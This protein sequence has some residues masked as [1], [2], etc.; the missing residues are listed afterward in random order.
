MGV[1]ARSKKKRRSSQSH[2]ADTERQREKRRPARSKHAE[3]RKFASRRTK[4]LAVDALA[5]WALQTDSSGIAVI[6]N[7]TI[8]GHNELFGSL[9]R[10]PGPWRRFGAKGRRTFR[11]LRELVITEAETLLRT[12]RS[13]AHPTWIQRYERQGDE[14]VEIRFEL[15]PPA[16]SGHGRRITALVL[17]VSDRLRHEH[18]LTETRVHLDAS[19]RMRALG[20]LASGIAHD[21]NNTLG[22]LSLRLELLHN[23]PICRNTHGENIDAIRRICADAA[24]RV[25]RLQD[26]GHRRQDRPLDNID[27]GQVVREAIDLARPEIE[28]NAQLDEIPLAI[29]SDVAELPPVRG[30]A[31]ELRHVLINLLLNARD[32][33]PRGGRIQVT[34]EVT[35]G[36][37][38][39]RVADEGV[40][41]PETHL[42]RIFDPFFS[43]KGE[44]GTGLGLAIAAAVLERHEGGITACNRPGGGAVLELELPVATTKCLPHRTAVPSALRQ[45]RR[46]ILIV[47]DDV[48]HLTAAQEVL[49]QAGQTVTSEAHGRAAIERIRAGEQFDVVLC[50]IGMPDVNGWEVARAIALTSPTTPVFMISGWAN[51][52]DEKD[53]RR[54][55]V[56]GV[57]AKPVSMETLFRALDEHSDERAQL[58]S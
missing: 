47:D 43:T 11:D 13:A 14:V 46:H 17:D 12:H 42:S 36:R 20:E 19:A 3:L 29:H 54:A 1:M 2:S 45:P 31:S 55:L 23:D 50:D 25:R 27:L 9:N 44:R 32:A 22:A 16:R 34:A 37:V 40:G 28:R 15:D 30:D 39:I 5:R 51:E 48:E 49:E 53:P 8:E 41:I 38:H 24:A 35:G 56:A 10:L 7:R 58:L 21:L 6:H 57:L 4:R 18:A 33:M 26:F 52:I